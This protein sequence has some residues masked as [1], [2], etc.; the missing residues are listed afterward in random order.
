MKI[1]RDSDENWKNDNIQFPR[2]IA[3]IEA[4]GGFTHSLIDEL[5]KS[6]DLTVYDIVELINRAQDKWD[7]I[8]ERT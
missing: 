3:E 7:K 4:V 8:K 1:S 2:L 5:K 6:M